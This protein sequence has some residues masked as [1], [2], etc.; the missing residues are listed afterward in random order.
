MVG[1]ACAE[2]LPLPAYPINPTLREIKLT[3]EKVAC[4]HAGLK[5][6]FGV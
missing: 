5:F 6:V 3:D 1:D 4:I 2:L